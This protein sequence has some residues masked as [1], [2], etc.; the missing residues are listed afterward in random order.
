MTLTIP[1]DLHRFWSL[2]SRAMRINLRLT[3]DREGKLHLRRAGRNDDVSDLDAAEEL[4][5]V[6]EGAHHA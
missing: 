1:M 3:V 6:A 4:I 5:A 2:Q